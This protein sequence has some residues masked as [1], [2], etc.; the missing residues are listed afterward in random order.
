MRMPCEGVTAIIGQTP[1]ISLNDVIDCSF[2]LYGKLEGLNPSGS[3]KDRPALEVLR[4]GI[5]SGVITEETVIVES[6]S[7]NVG[8]ALDQL[9]R[10]FGLRFICVTD[11]RVTPQNLR[12]LQIYGA[13]VE[14][15]TEPHP[16]T[17]EFLQARINRAREIC[18]SL[19]DA[20]WVNQYASL[21][22]VQAHYRTM[23]EIL[24][25]LNGKVDYLFC[26]ASSCG[27]LTG[28]AEY[29]KSINC[30]TKVGAVAAVASV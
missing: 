29:V 18:E 22:N 5:E 8:L 2:N 24:A 12:L 3:I 17:R 6:S 11:T 25:A 20:F 15:L 1:L 26:A 7:G 10:Y 21:L 19:E 13:K 23:E 14:V 30:H 4:Y 28:C 27:T 9:C 16:V